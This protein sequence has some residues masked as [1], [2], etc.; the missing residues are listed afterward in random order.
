MRNLLVILRYDGRAFHGWQ[1]QKN[2][3]TVMET[4]QNA[5]E[6]VL[7]ERPDVK[8]CS[9]T[10]AGV[11]AAMY[12]VSFHTQSGIPCKGLVR[13]LN[14]A[15]PPAAAAMDCREVEEDFH[16]RYCARGKRYV[17]RIRNSELRDPFWEGLSYRFLPPIDERMLNA[18]AKAFIGTHDFASFQNAGTN[19]T[20][21]VR[22]IFDCT[23][24]RRGE[25][26]EFTVS[27]DGFL[28][29]MVRIMAGTLLDIS[30][31]V[32]RPGCVPSVLAAKD[33]SAAGFTAP[34]CGLM[35]DEVFYDFEN[36]F[37]KEKTP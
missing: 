26:V 7:G 37:E 1:V 6:S 13:A 4:F 34:A 10:D 32:L 19:V 28:Y 22:T 23:V 2:A 15:L 30:R 5:L 18:E 11:H 36:L 33:R 35:L 9:R 27:G 3:V 29:N 12:G 31:G 20:D 17:Y 24:T 21:T 25:L 8:G 14:A 16:A